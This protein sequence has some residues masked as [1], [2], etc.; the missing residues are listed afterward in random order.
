MRGTLEAVDFSHAIAR[1]CGELGHACI[2]LPMSDGGEGF[3]SV[4][5]GVR[6]DVVVAGPL[7]EPVHAGF[8]LR[9]ST[10]VIEMAAAAGRALLP[11]PQ[12]DDPVDASTRG[13]GELL[14]A[15]RAAGATRI[16]VGC[17]GS[18]T[19]DGGAGCVEV[20]EA[21]GGLGDIELLGATDV[22]TPFLEAAAIFGPQKGATPAQV[23]ELTARLHALADEWKTT[24]GID[25]TMLERAGA[26]GG[27]AGGL[28][29]L[30]AR[31]VAGFDLVA[32]ELG[33]AD[34]LADADLLVTG[35]GRLDVT[36]LEGKTIASLVAL[37]PGG[38]RVLVIA[39]SADP[40]VVDVLRT[41][42]P[43]RLEVVDLSQRFGAEDAAANPEY[44]VEQVVRTVL[45][46]D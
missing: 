9:G 37:T 17:G 34:A 29:V 28:A 45:V 26:A 38:V 42:R 14:L 19:T 7:G 22:T 35:E 32:E 23:L 33:L 21:A 43:G 46:E 1:A 5:G 27:F 40:L 4:F 36:T 3:T 31:L 20:V 16:I 44:L 39:G 24:R 25:V 41:S 30:G 11:H 12:G 10:A 6:H 8:I 18:A 15:A 13:V 2:E